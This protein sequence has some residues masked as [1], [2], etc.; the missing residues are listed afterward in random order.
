MFLVFIEQ[1]MTSQ[2]AGVK[3]CCGGGKVFWSAHGPTMVV[4]R[5]IQ[6]AL[7][8][9]VQMRLQMQLRHNQRGAGDVGRAVLAL[10]DKKFN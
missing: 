7:A 4:T 3:V 2:W 5:P 6:S 10:A 8:Q 1:R 9:S